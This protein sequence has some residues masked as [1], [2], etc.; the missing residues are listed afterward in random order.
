MALW[1]KAP[2]LLS[3][4]RILIMVARWLFLSHFLVFWYW[5]LN[6]DAARTVAK[7]W[8]ELKIEPQ[9]A[10]FACLNQWNTLYYRYPGEIVKV[11]DTHGR[12]YFTTL[13]YFVTSSGVNPIKHIDL[14]NTRLFWKKDFDCLEI[15]KRLR[16]AITATY[17]YRKKCL[18]YSID[19]IRI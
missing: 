16:S 13:K 15:R 1:F 19:S 9:L 18:F 17:Y 5:A 3:V 4:S 11:S 2:N 10:N 12:C 8:F 14:S 6:F 7:N